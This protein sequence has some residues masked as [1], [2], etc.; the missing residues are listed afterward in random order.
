[1]PLDAL[2]EM[3][4]ISKHRVSLQIELAASGEHGNDHMTWKGVTGIGTI[5]MVN[6]VRRR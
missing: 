5:D 2:G 1:M 3:R 6:P 4:N